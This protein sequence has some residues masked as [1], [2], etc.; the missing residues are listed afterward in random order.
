MTPTQTA[1]L[2]ALISSSILT[3][4]VE[5]V[6]DKVFA[7]IR[8]RGWQAVTLANNQVYFGKISSVTKN[9]IRLTNIYYL[10]EDGA[11][12]GYPADISQKSMSLVKLGE[13]LHGPEDLMTIGRAHIVYVQTLKDSAQVVQAIKQYELGEKL[14]DKKLAD[15]GDT[16]KD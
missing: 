15:I 10:Q 2:A 3:V 6:G 16:P 7:R 8:Y 14:G 4:G 9:D 11:N 1:I 12:A 5:Y 13:E